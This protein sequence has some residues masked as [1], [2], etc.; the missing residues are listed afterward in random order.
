[1]KKLIVVAF[2]ALCL[3]GASSLALAEEVMKG[4]MGNMKDEMKTENDAM[5]DDMMVN[6]E[7]M[8]SKTKEQ[9][10]TKGKS[11]DQKKTKGKSKE[12]KEKPKTKTQTHKDSAKAAPAAPA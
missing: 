7:E 6:K 2:A 5:K 10:K 12:Q 3:I 4:E 11:K 9:G 8:K 1:M